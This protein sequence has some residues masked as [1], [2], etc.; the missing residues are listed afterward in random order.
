MPDND[1]NS[2]DQDNISSY[3]ANYADPFVE[4]NI[5]KINHEGKK[6]VIIQVKEFYELP[7]IC[8]KD[9]SEGLKNGA[10]Y[11]RT[12]RKYETAEV[13]SQTEMREIIESATNKGIKK[14]RERLSIFTE[15]IPK[16]EEELSEE[17]F[18]NQLNG[19]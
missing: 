11:T 1:F 19:L 17:K 7:I 6:Y 18:K 16:S 10:I 15:F 13:P 3:V 2:Y 9:G 4:F 14:F 12:R 8:K 5:N